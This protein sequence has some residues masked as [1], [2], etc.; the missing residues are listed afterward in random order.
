MHLP[1]EILRQWLHY[2]SKR[3][4]RTPTRA[5]GPRWSKAPLEQGD[6]DGKTEQ[7]HQ[8]QE[9]QCAIRDFL[10]NEANHTLASLA[11]MAQ[12]AV[13]FLGAMFAAGILLG[14]LLWTLLMSVSTPGVTW[15][16]IAVG[17]AFGQW[18]TIF[19]RRHSTRDGA[20]GDRDG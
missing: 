6:V 18:L 10:K 3:Q 12:P 8:P 9:S 19:L 1:K 7:A 4:P 13:G 5:I 16:V 20:G 11:A 2:R 17:A 14:A 15:L